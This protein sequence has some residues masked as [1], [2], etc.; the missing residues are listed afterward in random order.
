LEV[1]HDAN[2]HDTTMTDHIDT[3][4]NSLE[5]IYAAGEAHVE[6]FR[7][8]PLTFGE[9]EKTFH[10]LLRIAGGEA[11][12]NLSASV[13]YSEEDPGHHI[14]I[15][16][17]EDRVVYEIES[18]FVAADPHD[19]LDVTQALHEMYVQAAQEWYDYARDADTAG[20]E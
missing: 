20:G 3:Q 7:I 13:T 16:D 10:V 5:T 9:E 2:T 17:H 15:S 18:D 8:K 6:E 1:I 12:Y 11:V 19:S 4:E 14:I